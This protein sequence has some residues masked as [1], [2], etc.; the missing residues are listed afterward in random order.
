MTGYKAPTPS[1]NLIN[2]TR[3]EVARSAPT[4]FYKSIVLD[5]FA[6]LAALGFGYGYYWYLTQ[7]L[8]VWIL[9][10][11]LTLFAVLTVLQAFLAQHGGRTLAIIL[12][13]A[14]ALVGS[15]WQ[16]DTRILGIT[17]AVVMVFLAWGYLSARSRAANSVEIR[18]F[19]V[20]AATLT[21]FTTGLL[22]FMVL[23]YVPQ[24]SGNPLVVSQKSFR[25]FFDWA[26]GLVNDFYPSLSLNGS[27][28]NF[29]ESFAKMELTNN[30]NFKDLSSE[31][32]TVAVQEATQ[33]FEQS[34]SA[35]NTTS[36]IASSSPTSDA[37]YN[38][39]QGMMNAWR[40]KAGGWFDIG[41]A[42]VI[43]IALRSVGVIFIWF[44]EFISLIFYELLLATGYIK[45]G[46][47]ARMQETI[48]Y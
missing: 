12:L 27:F 28:G 46:E 15:F 25:T 24:L 34:L 21:K 13:E 3:I 14:L 40:S 29:S 44:A 42:A 30:P 18:F 7:G 23:I 19:E 4:G 22:I 6:V 35:K 38:I 41:W 43:F 45:V 47:A 37:F 16:D 36:P 8:A 2:P 32:Q 48:G 17:G 11:A 31:Q 20:A 39:L 9:L 10:I 1:Q 26:S 33:Q 5:V